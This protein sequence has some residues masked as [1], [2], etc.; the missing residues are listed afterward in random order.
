MNDRVSI[1][2]PLAEVRG[3]LK[4]RS[5]LKGR[6]TDPQARADIAE[7]LELQLAGGQLRRDLLIEFLHLIQDKFGHLSAAHM[8]ALAE[9]MKISQAEVYEVAVDKQ[10]HSERLMVIDRWGKVRG[11]F[12]C[13]LQVTSWRVLGVCICLAKSNLCKPVKSVFLSRYL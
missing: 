12:G 2:V 8:T 1:V 13:K 7:L 10:T 9:V 5:T 4:G 11:R 3:R 6:Q